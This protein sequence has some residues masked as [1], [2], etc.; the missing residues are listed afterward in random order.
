M[1]DLFLQHISLGEKWLNTCKQLT[2]IFWPNYGTNPWK[3]DIYQPKE[4]VDFV[5]LLKKVLKGNTYYITIA[6]L[7]NVIVSDSKRK[8]SSQ[9]T[10]TPFNTSRTR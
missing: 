8:N 3:E 2:E 4:L 10:C 9:T 5:E 7:T 1:A 6:H